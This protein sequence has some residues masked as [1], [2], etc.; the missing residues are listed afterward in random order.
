MSHAW[1]GTS[2]VLGVIIG[3]ALEAHAQVLGT[4]VLP[5]QEIGAQLVQSTVTAVQSTISAIEDVV[6]T[7]S[8]LQELVPL[9]AILVA[10]GIAEDMAALADIVRQAEGLSYD[11][12]SL[13][14]QI[15]A[16][17]NLD[18]APAST[19]EL[20]VRLAEIRRVR[21]QCYSYAMRLQTLLTTALRTVDH[22]VLLVNSIANFLGAKQGMQT[23]V[24][25]NATIS[26]TTTIHA[27]QTAAFQRAGS[28]D[29]M[30]QLLTIES[31]HRINEATMADW[32]RR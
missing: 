13:Q 17:F 27:T 1:A 8:A 19:S 15:D 9:D 18:T 5:V 24:Q 20:Q 14:A 31:L 11:I 25:L 7:A 12:A 6:Q 2:V 29:A 21:S 3:L 10:E 32:P 28:V 26:K 30:E 16:L 22:L 4:G 23:L